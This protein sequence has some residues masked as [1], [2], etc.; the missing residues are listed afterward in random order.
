MGKGGIAGGE[1]LSKSKTQAH[2][3]ALGS[4]SSTKY[5]LANLTTEEL[6]DWASAY[7]LKAVDDRTVLLSSLVRLMN[8]QKFFYFINIMYS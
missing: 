4:E 8:M 2:T 6:K 3:S 5:K 1:T 7:G